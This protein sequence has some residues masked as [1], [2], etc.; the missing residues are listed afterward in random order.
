MPLNLYDFFQTQRLSLENQLK[1]L[2]KAPSPPETLN[3]I[4]RRF[5][6]DEI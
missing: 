3:Q 1:L 5:I 6:P 4:F 2:K